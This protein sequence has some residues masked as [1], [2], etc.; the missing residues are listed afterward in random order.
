VNDLLVS[1]NRVGDREIGAVV[2]GG[3]TRGAKDMLSAG[4]RTVDKLAPMEAGTRVWE[5]QHALAGAGDPQLTQAELQ[6]G[7]RHPYLCAGR[8]S[9]G[10]LS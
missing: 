9:S 6:S 1:E 5:G 7:A 2:R 8:Y 4:W 3:V 10:R